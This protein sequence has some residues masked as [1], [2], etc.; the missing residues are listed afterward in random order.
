MKNISKQSRLDI[1]KG[2]VTDF[3]VS[4][5]QNNDISTQELGIILQEIIDNL[6]K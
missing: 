1:V 4:V 6:K 3:A 2:Q 5:A